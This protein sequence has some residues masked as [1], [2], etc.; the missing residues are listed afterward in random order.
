MIGRRAIVGLSL[1]SALLFC[2]IAASSAS[3]ATSGTTAFTCVENP[4][5]KGDFVD[6]HCTTPEPNKEGAYTH[7]AISK[8]PTFFTLSNNPSTITSTEANHATLKGVL[9]GIASEITCAT[10]HGHGTLEN[11]LSGEAH[12][13]VGSGIVEYT[14]CTMP[15][16]VTAEVPPKERCKVKEPIKFEATSTTKEKGAEMGVLFSPK[17]G[18]TFVKLAFENG[19]GGGCPVAGKEVAVTGSAEA[20]PSGTSEGRGAT[21]V[22]TKEMTKGTK[23]ETAEQTGVCLGGQV[24]E[25]T[26]TI[27]FQM[28]AT[29]EGSAENPI[30]LTTPPFTADL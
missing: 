16:P 8:N 13:V 20:T 7:K 15:K 22:F 17:E 14:N 25:F 30:T 6:P 4:E 23:C 24:A 5:G 10:V 1:L 21:L 3:A 9:G 18:K 28:T 19:P 29:T 26:S 2:A 11:K 12:S 27:V